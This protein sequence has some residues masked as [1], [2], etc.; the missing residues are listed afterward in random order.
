MKMGVETVALKM[1]VADEE[2]LYIA[3]LLD[4]GGTSSSMERKGKS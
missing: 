2:P 1:L 3:G 4:K